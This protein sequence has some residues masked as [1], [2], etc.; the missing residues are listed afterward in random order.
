MAKRAELFR[1][2]AGRLLQVQRPRLSPAATSAARTSS[3][4]TTT[5]AAATSCKTTGRHRRI[6]AR[7][8]AHGSENL[9]QLRFLQRHRR[10]VCV[11]LANRGSHFHVG[12]ISNVSQYRRAACPGHRGA[13]T[14]RAAVLIRGAIG[15]R[16][17]LSRGA[18]REKN[19]R[20]KAAGHRELA[21]HDVSPLDLLISGGVYDTK[22]E[23][24]FDAEPPSRRDL[25]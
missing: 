15:R 3:A 16:R 4:G 2:P 9:T 11:T 21:S 8:L 5:A 10:R 19:E 24:V 20:H 6:R 17:R 23:G 12:V 14:T 1:A 25:T 18:R 7:Q 13:M 22:T